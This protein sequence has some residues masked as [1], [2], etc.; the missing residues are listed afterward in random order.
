MAGGL[1]NR[2]FEPAVNDECVRVRP[3]AV[4]ALPVLGET[5]RKVGS[6]VAADRQ[7]V[8]VLDPKY[9]LVVSKYSR[10]TSRFSGFAVFRWKISPLC[11]RHDP[12]TCMA[13]TARPLIK[14]RLRNVEQDPHPSG[15]LWASG[16]SVAY[17]PT[18]LRFGS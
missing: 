12:L 10:S 18:R 7:G 11:Y 9:V 3:A 2:R 13:S 8:G 15:S 14:L 16:A 4:P 5:P 17:T 6:A 1:R